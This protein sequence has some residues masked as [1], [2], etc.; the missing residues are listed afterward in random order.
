MLG[1]PCLRSGPSCGPSLCSAPRNSHGNA[2]CAP[3]RDT[4]RNR[5]CSRSALSRR[6]PEERAA[7][8]GPWRIGPWSSV[9]HEC[10]I[11]SLIYDAHNRF[12]RETLG[13]DNASEKRSTPRFQSD[14]CGG[15]DQ[16]AGRGARQ[17]IRGA[18]FIVMMTPRSKSDSDLCIHRARHSSSNVVHYSTNGFYTAWQ[19]ESRRSRELRPAGRRRFERLCSADT[20]P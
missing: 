20:V 4:M 17:P 3:N 16:I 10:D 12:A 2:A 6:A 7:R 18:I 5:A 15:R 19:T 11:E 9:D 14:R 13:Q 8:G 1:M